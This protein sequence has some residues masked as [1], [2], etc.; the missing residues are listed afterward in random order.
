ME[1]SSLI[2]NNQQPYSFACSDRPMGPVTEKTAGHFEEVFDGHTFKG[3]LERIVLE[4]NII[5]CRPERGVK[6]VN[7]PVPPF[8]SFFFMPIV[9]TAFGRAKNFLWLK[10][11]NMAAYS[12]L[13]MM[14]AHFN[15]TQMLPEE[16]SEFAAQEAQRLAA[17]YKVPVKV[18]YHGDPFHARKHLP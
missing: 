7:S 11:P 8:Q 4:F 15:K 16:Y 18:V 2:S 13:N 12:S 6:L 17:T 5:L 1:E 14:P 10:L 9:Y 3:E